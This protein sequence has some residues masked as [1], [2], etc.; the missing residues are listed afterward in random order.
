MLLTLGARVS[1]E[2]LVELLE[3]CH[4]RIRH[5]LILARTLVERGSDASSD[6][7]REVAAQVRR[8]FTVALPQHVA[9]ED[10]TI[11]PHLVDAEPQVAAALRTLAADHTAHTSVIASL[12]DDLGA[13]E[14]DPSALSQIRTRLAW[15][16]ER[17]A[18]QLAE[19]LAL[20]ERVVFPALRRLPDRKRDE[21]LAAIRERRGG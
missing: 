11:A 20:E 18:F 8:Y 9:D 10:L 14:R 5:H 16:V 3:A 21:I 15:A 13:L 7:V 17:L 2:G 12:M 4:R 1:G 19:H 6:E